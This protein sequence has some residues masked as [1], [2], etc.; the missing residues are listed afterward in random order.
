[1]HGKKEVTFF[2]TV[3]MMPHTEFVHPATRHNAVNVR[4]VEQIGTPRMKDGGHAGTQSLIACKG[5]DGVP[6]GL[7]HAIVEGS[8]MVNGYRTQ[9]IRHR[10]YHMEILLGN[11]LL[12]AERNP[13]LTLL[14]LTLGAMTVTA[15]VVAYLDFA[16]LGTYLHMT[17]KGAGSAH[18]HMTKRFP[19]R[20]NYI[21]GTKKLLS[22]V[23]YNLTDVEACPHCLGGKRTSISRT[24]LL[25]SISAT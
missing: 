9:A 22:M 25:G 20:R 16:A 15:T 1:M 8:L 14:V 3:E 17:S 5:G 19:Y 21:M 18:R 10:E 4:M 23:T 11:N 7:E 6:C 2:A 24:C 13:L 12:P